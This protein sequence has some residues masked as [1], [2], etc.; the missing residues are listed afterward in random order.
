MH[1]S[2]SECIPPDGNS[3]MPTHPLHLAHLSKRPSLP[4]TMLS[5]LFWY[6][7]RVISLLNDSTCSWSFPS[8]RTDSESQLPYLHCSIITEW[9]SPRSG[10]QLFWIIRSR[11]SRTYQLSQLIVLASNPNSD[12]FFVDKGLICQENMINL[13]STKKLYKG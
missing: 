5:S 1:A 6:S 8:T 4:P 2:T 10:W 13:L 11:Q 3:L 9:L 7:S 12:C